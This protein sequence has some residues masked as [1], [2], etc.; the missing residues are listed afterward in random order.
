MLQWQHP[1]LLINRSSDRSFTWGMIRDKNH[2]INQPRLSRFLY[3]L[4]LQDRGLK[5]HFICHRGSKLSNFAYCAVHKSCKCTWQRVRIHLCNLRYHISKI[6][7]LKLLCPL[8]TTQ[9]DIIKPDQDPSIPINLFPLYIQHLFAQSAD[10]LV[11]IL[12]Q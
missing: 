7:I 11:S 5:H 12:K 9:T 3:S 6:I 4:T 8:K 1:G 10:L 2:L